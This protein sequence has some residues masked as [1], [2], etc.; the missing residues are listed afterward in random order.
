MALA[1]VCSIAVVHCCSC[2]F[3]GFCVGSLFCCAVLSGVSSF[4]I[5][6]LERKSLLLYLTCVLKSYDCKHSVYL[7]RSVVGLSA[8]CDFGI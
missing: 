8:V 2:S 4:A 6:P 3:V 7:P 1:A 5:I